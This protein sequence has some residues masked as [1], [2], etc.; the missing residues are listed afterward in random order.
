MKVCSRLF[1]LALALCV[2]LPVYGSSQRKAEI[3]S[4][5]IESLNSKIKLFSPTVITADA[6]S[7]SPSDRQAL[8]KII[9]AA[10]LLDPLFLRQVWNGNAALLKKLEAD[11]SPPGQARL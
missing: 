7:L 5:E 10:R 11:K 9:E 3:Q 2:L 1:V 6:S 4:S 8:A